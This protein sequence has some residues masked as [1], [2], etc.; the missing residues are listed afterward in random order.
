MAIVSDGCERKL[1]EESKRRACYSNKNRTIERI[2]IPRQVCLLTCS[3]SYWNLMRRGGEGNRK[4]NLF[5]LL[6]KKAFHHEGRDWYHIN[7]VL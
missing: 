5:E 2:E 4:G 1:L 7:Y 3:G 6:F